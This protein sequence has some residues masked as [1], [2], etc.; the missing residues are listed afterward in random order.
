VV[1]DLW[2]GSKF[3]QHVYTSHR[4][5]AAG[6]KERSDPINGDCVDLKQQDMLRTIQYKRN[7][8]AACVMSS[9]KVH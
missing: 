8:L 1:P 4:A 9:T 3:E 6:I 7:A 5:T 2:L